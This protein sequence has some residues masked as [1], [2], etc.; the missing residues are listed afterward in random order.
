M[1]FY[2]YYIKYININDILILIICKY[3]TIVKRLGRFKNL[4]H[5][6]F[7]MIMSERMRWAEHVARMVEKNTGYTK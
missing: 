4:I 3:I 5:Y 2:Y 7:R 1:R 6:V